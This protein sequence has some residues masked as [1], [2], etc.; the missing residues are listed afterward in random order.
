MA[1][2]P[3]VATMGERGQVVIPKRLRDRL[4]LS[5]QTK[6]AVYGVGDGVILLKRLDLPELDEA[7]E[8]IFRLVEEKGLDLSEE[9]VAEEVRAVRKDRRG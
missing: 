6:F 3:D 2:E 7:W 1:S 9:E 4:E 8:R 5:P